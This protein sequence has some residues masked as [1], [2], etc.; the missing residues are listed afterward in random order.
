[1]WVWKYCN[2]YAYTCCF[3]FKKTYFRSLNQTTICPMHANVFC[4]FPVYYFIVFI[5]KKKL[6]PLVKQ[7][8]K[9]NLQL[10]SYT[11]SCMSK[12]NNMCRWNTKKK[13]RQSTTSF[14]VYSIT[15]TH[16]LHVSLIQ[17]RIQHRCPPF[18]PHGRTHLDVR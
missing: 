9:D 17:N 18:T 13:Q 5:P 1:M 10:I 8:T 11:T 15:R 2:Y 12:E 4:N 3:T 16:I 6:L 7:C 14:D